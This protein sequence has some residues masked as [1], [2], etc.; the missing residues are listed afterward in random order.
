MHLPRRRRELHDVCAV[1]PPELEVASAVDLPARVRC[2][3]PPEIDE[4]AGNSEHTVVGSE[5]RGIIFSGLR[6]IDRS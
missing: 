1:V 4:S 5:S 2:P 6:S 3:L